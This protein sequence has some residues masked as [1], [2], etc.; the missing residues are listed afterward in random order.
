MDMGFLKNGIGPF[1]KMVA[2]MLVS[3]Q[4]PTLMTRGTMDEHPQTAPVRIGYFCGRVGPTH[5]FT[6]VFNHYSRGNFPILSRDYSFWK[7][8]KTPGEVAGFAK[9]DG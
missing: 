7:T 2:F 4:P 9:N 3:L 5:R 8:T 6:R 1:P